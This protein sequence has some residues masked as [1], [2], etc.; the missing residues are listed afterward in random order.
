LYFVSPA[1][2]TG[3]VSAVDAEPT[4]S[5]RR[6]TNVR[7]TYLGVRTKVN[8]SGGRPENVDFVRGSWTFDSP[9]R[10]DRSERTRLRRRAAEH[11][12]VVAHPPPAGNASVPATS[13]SREEVKTKAAPFFCL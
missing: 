5:D 2:R 1:I 4:P 3:D 13:P 8:D 12:I 6:R 11:L 7:M 10:S 9:V